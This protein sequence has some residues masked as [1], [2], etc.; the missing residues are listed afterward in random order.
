MRLALGLRPRPLIE[1]ACWN[2]AAAPEPPHILEGR[3][4]LDFLRARV[5][6][7]ERRGRLVGIL[8]IGLRPTRDQTPPHRYKLATVPAIDHNID[9]R[10]RRNVVSRPQIMRRLP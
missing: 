8:R 2:D 3:L 4:A 7:R 1:A 5:E 6:R 10:R 9:R